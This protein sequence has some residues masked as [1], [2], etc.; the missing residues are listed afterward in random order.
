[1]VVVNGI[2][3]SLLPAALGKRRKQEHADR[4]ITECAVVLRL[5][6]DDEQRSPLLVLIRFENE[7]HILFQPRIRP[8]RVVGRLVRITCGMAITETR[9]LAI[10]SA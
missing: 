6:P 3:V 9:G 10:A 5:I 1:M 7:R 8:Q 2:A 4:P